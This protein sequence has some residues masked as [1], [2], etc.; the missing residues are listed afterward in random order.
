VTWVPCLIFFA[1]ILVREWTIHQE[2]SEWLVERRELTDRVQAPERLPS[3]QTADFV[4]PEVELD[5]FN[6]VGVIS[7]ASDD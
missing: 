3:A 5:E 2:R 6:L 1:L 4:L 7:E